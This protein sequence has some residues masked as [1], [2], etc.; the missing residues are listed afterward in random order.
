MTRSLSF[1]LL[2]LSFPLAAQT[3]VITS[4]DPPVLPYTG[5]RVTIHGQNLA[6]I[7][8]AGLPHGVCTQVRI[9]IDGQRTPV[10]LRSVEPSRLVVDIGPREIGPA[11][12]RIFREDRSEVV[13]FERLN[14]TGAMDAEMILVPLLYDETPGAFG[15]RWATSFVGWSGFDTRNEPLPP[16]RS[17]PSL[18]MRQDRRRA[19]LDSLHLRVRDLNREETSWG[20]EI[21]VVRERDF[22]LE[23]LHL[24][25]VPTDRRFRVSL[26]IYNLA[27]L[28]AAR[29]PSEFVLEV[30][31]MDPCCSPD[32]PEQR[33]VRVDAPGAAVSGPLSWGTPGYLEL[34]DFLAAY[35]ETAQW[36]TVRITV[37]QIDYARANP[38]LFW[39]FASITHNVT[40]HVT[41]VTPSV[42]R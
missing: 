19:E 24:L 40:Q 1:V 7:S 13:G 4:I 16:P 18:F 21:P 37:R 12:V 14:F 5:G 27:P 2:L 10:T 33:V 30:V 28:E 6:G 29:Q 9:E 15:S 11:T 26:R 3:G 25:D 8:C 22:R 38:P 31:R 39:A 20:T 42:R 34:N 36:R 17:V 35:P 41:L 23:V 32:F